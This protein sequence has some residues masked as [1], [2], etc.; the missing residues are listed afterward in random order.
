MRILTRRIYRAFPELDPYDDAKCVEFV[1]AAR[2]GLLRLVHSVAILGVGAVGLIVGCAIAANFVTMLRPVGDP[3]TAEPWWVT[4]VWIVMCVPVL[5]AGPVVAYLVRD[6]L[7]RG[8]IRYVLRTKG[9]CAICGYSLIGLPIGD[10]SKVTCPECAHVSEVDAS[11]GV[12]TLGEGHHARVMPAERPSAWRRWA[13]PERKA[14]LRRWAIAIG[15]IAVGGPAVSWGLY[16]VFL[17]RQA[18]RARADRAA[19]AQNALSLV[20]GADESA[21]V[22]PSAWSAVMRVSDMI[23]NHV[24][25]AAMAE[26]GSPTAVFPD[27]A[28]IDQPPPDDELEHLREAREKGV[29]LGVRFLGEFPSLGVY[30]NMDEITGGHATT[31]DLASLAS[32]PQTFTGQAYF[33]AAQ[34]L[35]QVNTGRM[36]LALKSGNRGEYLRALEV[37]LALARLTLTSP[38]MLGQYYGMAIER[39]ALGAVRRDLANF[40]DASWVEGIAGAIDRQRVDVRPDVVLNGYRASVL[41][42]AAWFFSIESN[43]RFG[44]VSPRV[45]ALGVQASLDRPLGTYEANKAAINAAFDRAIRNALTP[46]PQREL[47]WREPLPTTLLFA[48]QLLDLSRGIQVMDDGRLIRDATRA[49]VGIEWFRRANGRLPASLGELAPGYIDAVPQDAWDGLA[50]KFVPGHDDPPSYIV[51]SVGSDGVDDGGKELPAGGRGR[52]WSW[53]NVH[54]APGF[55]IVFKP[56]VK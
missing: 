28:A 11:L 37:N 25:A 42:T 13:T 15:I 4:F 24:A 1:A 29:A 12:L 19:L 50:L 14:R 41:D 39:L 7:L 32:G 43:A 49:L 22:G 35:S 55:D 16:E 8:R 10:E 47:L 52:W 48:D 33:S 44:R 56:G 30:E 2:R 27:Y 40:P 54:D 38:G 26:G 23:S 5:G 31:E 18:A 46:P 9:S 3:L 36:I 51:Y 34:R 53:G 45:Q 6:R 17:G 21:R 20:P